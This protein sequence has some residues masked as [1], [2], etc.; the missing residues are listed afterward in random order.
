[1]EERG[2]VMPLDLGAKGSCHIGGNVATNAGGLRF[3]R[4]GSLRGTVLGLEVVSRG[5]AVAVCLRA[6][7]ARSGPW[8]SPTVAGSSSLPRGLRARCGR[9][10]LARLCQAHPSYRADTGWHRCMRPPRGVRASSQTGDPAPSLTSP[11]FCS[12]FSGNMWAPPCGFSRDHGVSAAVG[13]VAMNMLLDRWPSAVLG[14][15]VAFAQG[16][17]GHTTVAAP[18]TVQA[19]RAHPGFPKAQ[20]LC[21][22][23]EGGTS[24]KPCWLPSPTSWG[25]CGL[26]LWLQL[27]FIVCHFLMFT[28][29]FTKLLTKHTKQ[30]LDVLTEQNGGAFG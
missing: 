13:T 10:P 1:M 26:V 8:V 17:P 22:S 3:L 6:G 9:E 11:R 7:L 29:C 27:I 24:P 12:V 19:C 2:F 30:D 5:T 4:Y 20:T 23:P 16:S 14:F 15:L 28:S 18:K 21:C 25:R